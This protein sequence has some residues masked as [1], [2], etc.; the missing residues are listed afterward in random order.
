[1]R[2]HAGHL[3]PSKGELEEPARGSHHRRLRACGP[4]VVNNPT[5]SEYFWGRL[6]NAGCTV[7]KVPDSPAL[8]HN[9]H[10]RELDARESVR[11]IA[12]RRTRR[13][14]LGAAA[15]TG[16][17]GARDAGLYARSHRETRR[18]ETSEPARPANA[19][20]LRTARGAP[21]AVPHSGAALDLKTA[22]FGNAST[23]GASP[24]PDEACRWT[25]AERRSVV[26]RG[27]AVICVSAGRRG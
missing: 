17:I 1:M 9:V 12:G 15:Q 26:L 21:E 6:D 23:N 7:P 27:A 16:T 11:L 13:R 24:Q 14:V 22:Q 20:R 5:R 4:G 19:A 25:W 18:D 10:G 2:G 3:L 8:G